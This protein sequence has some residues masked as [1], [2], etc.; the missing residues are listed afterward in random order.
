MD[1]E[2]MKVP[3][4]GWSIV[5]EIG[6]G[7]YGKV[8]EIRRH[9]LDTDERSAMKVIPVPRDPAEIRDY[10]E[11]GSI[12]NS[13]NYP[14]VQLGEPEA[15]RVLVLHEN[16]PNMISNITAAASKEGINIENM[17]NKSKKDMSVTVMEMA[18]L[19]S[20]HALNT[21]AELPG[22]IRIRTFAK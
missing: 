22:I 5:R 12:H 11:L 10:L 2:N 8:Y 18:E 17:I 4:Q 20:A 3:F 9:L 21:L 14:E 13:V 19:P 7:G 6:H 15:V 16:I 1:T